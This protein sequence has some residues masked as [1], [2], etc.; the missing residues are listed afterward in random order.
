LDATL[1]FLDPTIKP[2]DIRSRRVPHRPPYCLN[3]CGACST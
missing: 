3:W 2:T 1:I